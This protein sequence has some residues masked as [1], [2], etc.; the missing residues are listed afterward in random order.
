MRRSQVDPRAQ[1]PCTRCSN[2]HAYVPLHDQWSHLDHTRPCCRCE[3][4][5]AV[6]KRTART[7]SVTAKLR[8]AGAPAKSCATNGVALAA[9]RALLALLLRFCSPRGQWGSYI[10]LAAGGPRLPGTRAWRAGSA[11]A[12]GSRIAAPRSCNCTEVLFAIGALFFVGSSYA[13]PTRGLC[14]S[15]RW[16]TLALAGAQSCTG[17]HT[18][19]P[20]VISAGWGRTGTSSLKARACA[21][22]LSGSFSRLAVPVLAPPVAQV[23]LLYSSQHRPALSPQVV[24]RVPLRVAYK[25]ACGAGGAGRARPGPVLPCALLPVPHGPVRR[26]VRVRQRPPHGPV[27]VPGARAVRRLPRGGG[28]PAAAHSSRAGVLPQREGTTCALSGQLTEAELHVLCRWASRGR[29]VAPHALVCC[30]EAKAA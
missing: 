20:V 12:G 23:L 28:H 18:A 22:S 7:R 13:G 26:H 2:L 9:V 14:L 25:L 29:L 19:G 6:A 15:D 3:E 5:A 21:L 10:S 11:R 24:S 27:P 1:S 4:P 30:G 16:L 8:T 17:K